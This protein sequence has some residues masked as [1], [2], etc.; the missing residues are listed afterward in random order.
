MT[1]SLPRREPRLDSQLREP[2]VFDRGGDK[3]MELGN[4]HEV[5]DRLEHGWIDVSLL[6][7]WI[8]SCTQP[9]Q[10]HGEVGG[11]TDSHNRQ[12][13]HLAAIMYG[14]IY[15]VAVRRLVARNGHF[16]FIARL[17]Q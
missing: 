7:V 10:R 15:Y 6:Q 4:R 12:F 11:I 1:R 2:R 9:L 3:S 14:W 13:R 16:G 17:I 5:V 8:G